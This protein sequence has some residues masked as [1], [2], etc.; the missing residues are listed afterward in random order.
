[1]NIQAKENTVK[2]YM[3]IFLLPILIFAQTPDYPDTLIAH[4]SK[5]Y[6]CRIISVNND[7]I[8]LNFGL[9]K[10]STYTIRIANEIILE[11]YG[12]VYT[13]KAGF[14]TDLK[15]IQEYLIKRNKI[16]IELEQLDS[17]SAVANQVP[18]NSS[19]PTSASFDGVVEEYSFGFFYSPFI[20]GRKAAYYNS[21]YGDDIAVIDEYSTKVESQFAMALKKKLYLSLNVVYSSN[22]TKTRLENHR[23]YYDPV[24]Q[25]DSGEE[26]TNSL[27]I[28][29]IETGLKYYFSDFVPQNTSAFITVG[30]CKKFAFV[31][32]EEKELFEDNAATNNTKT[33]NNINEFLEDLNGPFLLQLG[34]GAE[35]FF[36]KSLSIHSSIRFYYE[37]TS[38]NHK[39][40]EKSDSRETKLTLKVED[41]TVNTNIGFGLNFYF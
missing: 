18:V 11:L 22:K 39:M 40:T 27:K 15:S 24:N 14:T 13:R 6:P 3:L 23:T 9:N 37:T 8:Q 38:A 1:M 20:E 7:L 41:D 26:T 4:H 30:H 2:K 5:V 16:Y 31:E 32:N 25:Y 34:F 36:N 19:E 21:S 35:Y 12:S 29:T 10:S 33:T 28:F 17:V